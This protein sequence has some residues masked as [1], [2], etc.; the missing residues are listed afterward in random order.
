M[1]RTAALVL[2]L[3]FAVPVRGA[4]E[5]A[6]IALNF[7]DVEL[8]VLAKFVSDVTGRNFIVD[9]RVRGKVTIISPTRITPDEAYVVFQSVLQVKGF[10]TVPSGSF[11]KIVPVRD[12]R[13][14]TDEPFDLPRTLERALL[15]EV[16]LGA[17]TDERPPETD[18]LAQH[19]DRAVA[20][21]RAGHRLP[22]ALFRDN[23]RR[24]HL[25]VL[26]QWVARAA[27]RGPEGSATDAPSV[28]GPPRRVCFGRPDPHGPPTENRDPIR[29]SVTVPGRGPIEVELHGTTEPQVRLAGAENQQAAGSLILASSPYGENDDRDSLRGL[30]DVMAM[31][32]SSKER[33]VDAPVPVPF[34]MV[35]RPARLSHEKSPPAHLLR[36]PELTPAAARGYLG[37]L[38]GALLGGLHPYLFPSDAIFR[39]A[40]KGMPILDAIEQTRLDNYYRDRSASNQGPVP[41]PFEYPAPNQ[42][43]AVRFQSE[44]FGLL[45]AA[46]A[47]AKGHGQQ[48]GDGDGD[49]EAAVSLAE[50]LR[51]DFTRGN[52]TSNPKGRAR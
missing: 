8:P 36:F 18:H 47:A 24:R 16:L 7:Q 21:Y 15:N 9:D 49:A 28:L 4:S 43:D 26:Q 41:N 31:A 1:K 42:T 45:L 50:I 38:A 12:A 37:T 52:G 20:R 27:G 10:T 29:L 25:R 48:T 23:V 34:L 30:V 39:G 40:D 17:W 46:R 19:Y 35:C 2:L 3:A 14:T 5:D 13:E 51:P 33:P 6:T 22:A 32:A 11:V 44:R